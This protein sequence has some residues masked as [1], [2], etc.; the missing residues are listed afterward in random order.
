MPEAIVEFLTSGYGVP[1]RRG[2]PERVWEP[3]ST[4]AFG[5]RERPGLS[6]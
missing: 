2:M 6:C 3:F 1:V 4:C 5:H